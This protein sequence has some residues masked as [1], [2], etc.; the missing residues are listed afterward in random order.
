MDKTFGLGHD[1]TAAQSW[2]NGGSPT[3]G[4]LGV[5]ATGPF[6]GFYHSIAAPVTDVLFMA[7]LLGVGTALILGTGMRL[8]TGAGALL[9]IM[10]WTAVLPPAGNPFMDEHLVYAAV[11]IVLP[12]LGTG[13]TLGLGR[14]WSAVSLVR[15][16]PWL[17]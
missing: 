14:F 5:V 15:R 4:F 1:T 13:N 2:L 3:K 12:W 16:T 17:Q 11:L 8:A 9:I 6:A 7:T 10:M